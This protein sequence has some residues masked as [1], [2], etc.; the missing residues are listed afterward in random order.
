MWN[1][2]SGNPVMLST[3]LT[4]KEGEA[5]F[6][7]SAPSPKVVV[8]MADKRRLQASKQGKSFMAI[9]TFAKQNRL[10]VTR[11][12]SGKD[13]ELVIAGKQGQIYEHADGVLAVLFM[14]PSKT[15]RYG[16]WCPKVWGNFRRAG[17]AARMTVVL[18]GDSEGAMTFDADSQEQTELALK[19]ARIHPKRTVS[20]GVAAA[21]EKARSTRRFAGNVA[22]MA[23]GALGTTIYARVM[24]DIE[25]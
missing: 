10:K 14:A 25:T 5:L 4:A 21:L 16:R 22:G 18:N 17:E 3:R 15:D 8:E 6:T 19:M 7:N 1:Q 11:V 20:A 12:G 23:A 24:P 2:T 13:A 9:L